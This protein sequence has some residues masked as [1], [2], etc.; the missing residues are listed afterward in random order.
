LLTAR[1]QGEVL[2]VKTYWLYVVLGFSLLGISFS[3]M[4]LAVA[5]LL[6]CSLF[7][8]ASVGFIVFSVWKS[9][10]QIIAMAGK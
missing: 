2:L 3:V 1:W 8:V 10:S 7:A 4:E 6:L 5:V 9:A